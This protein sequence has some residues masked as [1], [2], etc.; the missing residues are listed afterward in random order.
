MS[1]LETYREKAL[2]CMHVADEAHQS[3]ERVELLGLAS[4]YMALADYVDHRQEHGSAHR[5]DQDRDRQ[6][7]R[8]SRGLGQPP[9]LWRGS[10]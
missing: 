8:P 5:A 2:K 1:N 4:V 10:S 3:G 6:K 7:D 9:T